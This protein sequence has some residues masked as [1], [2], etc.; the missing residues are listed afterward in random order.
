M[1]S[2][3]V[4]MLGAVGVGKGTQAKKL[5]DSLKVPH[6]STG[7]ILRAE[8]QAGTELGLKAKEIMDRGDLV[9]DDI[10]IDMVRNRLNLNDAGRGAI[11]DGFP[12]TIPQ[13]EALGALLKELGL[14]DPLVV[15]IELPDDVIIERLSSR[16]VCINCGA[17]FNLKTDEQLIANHKCPTGTPNVIHRDD[18]QPDTIKRRLEVYREKTAPLINYYKKQGA[19]RPVSGEGSQDEVFARVLIAL[20]PGLI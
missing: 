20:D 8:V 7:D 11:F 3:T 12:R 9:S 2:F 13:A 18:D 6:I 16:R 1:A 17:T 5:V 19:L 10:I 14:P 4:I 15:S